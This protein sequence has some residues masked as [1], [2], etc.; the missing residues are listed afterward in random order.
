VNVVI[1]AAIGGG[2]GTPPVVIRTETPTGTVTSSHRVGDTFVIVGSGFSTTTAFNTVTFDGVPAASVNSDPANPTQRLIVSVPTGIPG[3]PVNSGD[4]PRP[5]V[6]LAVSVSGSTPGT[7][8]V[9][10]QPPS[11]VPLPDITNFT[12]SQQFVLGSVT[13]NGQNFSNVMSRNTVSLAGTNATLTSASPGQIVFTVPDLPGLGLPSG[14]S[15]AVAITVTV[16]DGGGNVIGSDVSRLD[17][18]PDGQAPL[19]FQQLEDP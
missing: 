10:V 4:P 14:S 17:E 18:H 3:A 16:R 7:F 9:T 12:P 11:A 5:G 15:L 6:M 8:S 13:L 1:A 2:T 19:A